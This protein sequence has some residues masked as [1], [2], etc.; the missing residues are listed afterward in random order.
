[1]AV[2]S[3]ARDGVLL[4]LGLMLYGVGAALGLGGGLGFQRMPLAGQEGMGGRSRA[5][6]GQDVEKEA[7]QSFDFG[8]LDTI[9]FTLCCN[10][11]SLYKQFK[12]Y[13]V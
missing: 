8:Y 5:E 1:M 9:S 4:T 3:T 2:M 10:F 12:F 11:P 7:D 6:R 13:L